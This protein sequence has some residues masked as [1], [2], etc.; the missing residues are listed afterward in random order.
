VPLG[1]GEKPPARL[2][3]SCLRGCRVTIS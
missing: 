3:M 2:W 1:I